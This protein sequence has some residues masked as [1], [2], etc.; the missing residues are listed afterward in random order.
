[1]SKELATT[2]SRGQIKEAQRGHSFSPSD[3]P[4]LTTGTFSKTLKSSDLKSLKGI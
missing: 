1:M 4:L 2:G 3:L